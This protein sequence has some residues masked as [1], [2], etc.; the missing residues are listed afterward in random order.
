MIPKAASH[1]NQVD[2]FAVAFGFRLTDE[3][4]QGIIGHLDAHRM[5][6][7]GLTGVCDNV[8]A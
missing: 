6:I 8:F 5:L 1:K 7:L 3:E 2:N 4:V